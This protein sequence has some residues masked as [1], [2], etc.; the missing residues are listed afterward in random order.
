MMKIKN[1]DRLISVGDIEA[2]RIVLDI[3]E[4]SLQSLDVYDTTRNLLS[5]DGNILRIG[6]LGW[7][8]KQ[9]RRLLV[10]GAGKASGSMAKAVEETLGDRI[11]GGLVIVKEL[12]PGDKLKR[13]ELVVGGHPLPNKEGLLGSKRILNMV[14]QATSEDLF[15]SVIRVCL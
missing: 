13:I 14:E 4:S 15:I 12:N 9:K 6:N 11:N 10:I 7:D 1:R 8:I 5:L 2:R 3:I